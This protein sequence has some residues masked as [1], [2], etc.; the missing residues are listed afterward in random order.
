[1]KPLQDLKPADD[2]VSIG[3]AFLFDRL[4]IGSWSKYFVPTAEH[5]KAKPKLFSVTLSSQ[6]KTAST[7]LANQQKAL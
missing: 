2:K 1:M 7:Q 5:S 3:F 4:S 6:L